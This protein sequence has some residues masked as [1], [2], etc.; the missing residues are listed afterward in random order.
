MAV[1][2]LERHDQMN[3]TEKQ[4]LYAN[5]I[6]D[7]L[8]IERCEG[9]LFSFQ[10][11]ISQHKSEYE[12]SKGY[13]NR[14]INEE[15]KWIAENPYRKRV[16]SEKFIRFICDNYYN[17][18]GCYALLDDDYNVLYIGKSTHLGA[19]VFSS[20]YERDKG[21]VE[22]IALLP[23]ASKTDMNIMELVLIAKYKPKYNID[24]KEDDES[25][26]FPSPVTVENDFR[27]YKIELREENL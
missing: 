6:A 19:R 26:M 11:Y 2:V 20:F 3:P 25:I 18:F 5:A 14:R 4:I 27:K 15:I 21:D 7:A 9:D 8:G 16:P 12:S 1:F 10:E 23:L 17:S 13:R 22:Y 24:S